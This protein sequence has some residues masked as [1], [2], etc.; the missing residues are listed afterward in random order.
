MCLSVCVE[1]GG[2]G[3]TKLERAGGRA[4]CVYRVLKLSDEDEEK[5]KKWKEE[6]GNH[7]R[8]DAIYINGNI[9]LFILSS[10]WLYGAALVMARMPV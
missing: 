8:M 2:G 6:G 4:C 9:L 7:A 10:L 3:D 1:L 5:K